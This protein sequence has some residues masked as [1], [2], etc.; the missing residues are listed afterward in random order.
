MGRVYGASWLDAPDQP[1]LVDVDG[2]IAFV[3]GLADVGTLHGENASDYV[4]TLIPLRTTSDAAAAFGSYSEGFDLPAQLDAIFDQDE[5]NGVGT[6]YAVNVFDPSRHASPSDVTN[7]DIKGAIDALGQKTGLQLAYDIYNKIG[8]FP[9]FLDCGAH[10]AKTGIRAELD[11]LCNKLG[12][13]TFINAPFGVSGNDVIE[14]RGSDGDFDLQIASRNV[15][16]AWPGVRILNEETGEERIDVYSSRLLGIALAS[17]VSYGPARGIS[18]FQI[19]GIEGSEVPV[20]YIPGDATGITHALRA[21]GVVTMRTSY[22]QGP[23]TEGTE[24]SA[25]PSDTDVRA[26]YH[27]MLTS[28]LLRDRYLKY[29]DQYKDLPASKA[30]IAQIEHG[31]NSDL[32]TLSTGDYPWVYGGSFMFDRESTSSEMARIGDFDF[33]LDYSPITLMKTM[34][35]QERFNYSYM[36]AALGLST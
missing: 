18:N 15:V 31:I 5:G 4:E 9:K 26:Q 12:A 14:A 28:N 8:A 21:A 16:I 24:S 25:W 23:V 32:A 36:D 35:I 34:T 22:G 7:L 17:L 19:K 10:A 33:V 20:D 29:M 30:L 1:N 3:V 11:V 13:I 2:A 6:V 27:V